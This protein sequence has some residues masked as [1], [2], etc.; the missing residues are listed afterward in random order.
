MYLINMAM[1]WVKQKKELELDPKYKLPKMRYKGDN[2]VTPQTMRM[3]TKP[4][5]TEMRDIPAD[6]EFPL[7]TKRRPITVPGP[8]KAS[9][10]GPRVD[11]STPVSRLE[12]DKVT[13][14]VS[15]IAAQAMQ[16]S[17]PSSSPV[18]KEG[19]VQPRPSNAPPTV[20]ARNG[21]AV[22]SGVLMNP[23]INRAAC[24]G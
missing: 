13:R 5:V 18:Q 3:D 12:S 19:A 1:G 24:F 16:N 17:L 15:N 14:A 8:P 22:Q 4:L 2:G 6:P 20:A 11:V 7:L 9:K 23:L 10:E 21:S